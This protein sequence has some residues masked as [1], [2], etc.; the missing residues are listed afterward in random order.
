MF[1]MAIS[2]GIAE[3]HKQRAGQGKVAKRGAGVDAS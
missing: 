1:T 2:A 3:H